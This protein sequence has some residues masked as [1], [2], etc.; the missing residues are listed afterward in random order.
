MKKIDVIENKLEG[1]DKS[2]NEVVFK[3]YSE[4]Q[5]KGFEIAQRY[6]KLSLQDRINII[7]ETFG[8]KTADIRTS[9][10]T[11]KWRGTSDISLEL[12]NGSSLFI[13]NCR[14][15]Q[16]KTAR[17]KNEY[18]NTI[19]AQYNPEILAEIKARITPLL[20]KREAE[21][22]AIAVQKGLKPYTF[23][24]V[25]INDGS[26]KQSGSH[27]GW[28]YVTVAVNGKI[29]A[30]VETGLSYGIARG[31]LSESRPDYFVAGALKD[32]EV[33]FVFNN[34]GHSSTSVLYKLHL[35]DN[36]RER[37]EKTLAKR[38]VV[39]MTE[40]QE[41]S[42]GVETSE[43]QYDLGYGHKGNGLTVWNRLEEKAGDYVTVAHIGPDRNVTFFDKAMP[44]SVKVRIEQVA[45][46]S[47]M[48]I[49]AT[50]EVP[51]FNTLA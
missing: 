12:D 50:Q 20:L 16:A 19:L 7:A 3:E 17:V 18:V 8:C 41:V 47:N 25:E 39:D 35:S 45:H 11:N 38:L 37:A 26:E 9:P 24:N 33:D 4:L 46:T 31:V 36:A 48:T 28:Y 51:V 30:F 42:K 15:P 44:Y 23:L 14:T 29:L 49:S 27:L 21:D 6:E 5:Q 32:N 13:G 2:Q 1:N 22:N 34:V 40:Q 43:K 10:C